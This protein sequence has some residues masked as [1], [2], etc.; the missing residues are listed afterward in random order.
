MG[1]LGVQVPPLIHW[2]W[3]VTS[4][5]VGQDT[6]HTVPRGMEELYGSTSPHSH[7]AYSLVMSS[8]VL[9]LAMDEQEHILGP[10]THPS[11]VGHCGVKVS[12]DLSRLQV[13][14]P[15]W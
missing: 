15:R 9:K 11:V 1:V 7:L 10:L 13:G 2:D 3:K 14:V 5:H 6:V 8:S 4:F 12:Q